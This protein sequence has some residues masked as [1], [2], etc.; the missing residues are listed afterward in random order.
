MKGQ[1]IKTSCMF[2]GIFVVY[3]KL[4]TKVKVSKEIIYL[5][6][7]LEVQFGHLE[8]PYRQF[9]HIVD[10]FSQTDKQIRTGEETVRKTIYSN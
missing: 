8:C 10:E 3:K 1:A 9:S 2:L 6:F 7:Y 4:L 5:K